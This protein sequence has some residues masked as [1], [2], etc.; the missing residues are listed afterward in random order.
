MPMWPK[1]SRL[2]RLPHIAYYPGQGDCAMKISK[3]LSNKREEILRIT[4]AHGANNL[5]LFGSVSRG[6]ATE[7]SDVDIL[8]KLEPGRTLLDIVA[9]K[10]DLED[11]LGCKVDVVTE[12]AVSPYIREQILKDAVNL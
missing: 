12:D 6:E 9:I 11:L 8:V 5:R 3:T 7:N 1:P 4:A 10:Q 2:V